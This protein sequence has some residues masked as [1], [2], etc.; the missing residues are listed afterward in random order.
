LASCTKLGFSNRTVIAQATR[1][2]PR[3]QS[4]APIEDAAEPEPA[5]AP[6]E[7]QE[8]VPVKAKRTRAASKKPK[9]T[10]AP[11]EVVPLIT[12]TK[13]STIAARRASRR[14]AG[15]AALDGDSTM[16]AMKDKTV[17]HNSSGMPYVDRAALCSG[18]EAWFCVGV[19]DQGT[20]YPC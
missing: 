20:V 17:R 12:S 8:Q 10:P 1:G 7:Q 15:T 3:K 16:K 6:A 9:T 4:V 13:G 2:R 19:S 5:A 11:A 14:V 18:Q